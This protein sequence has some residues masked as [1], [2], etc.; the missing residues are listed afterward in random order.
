MFNYISLNLFPRLF[1]M[2]TP[3]QASF[4][5]QTFYYSVYLFATCLIIY[6]GRLAA[7]RK[8]PQFVTYFALGGM[9][10]LLYLSTAVMDTYKRTSFVERVASPA[11]L[12][13]EDPNGHICYYDDPDMKRDEC[14]NRNLA[15]WRSLTE[16]KKNAGYSE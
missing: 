13:K 6:G 10:F 8:Y 9:F 7:K 14:F 2:D 15:K 4:V 16:A 12:V 1:Q 11:S 5:V 3:E